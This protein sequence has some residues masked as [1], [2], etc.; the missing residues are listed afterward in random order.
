MKTKQPAP[1]ETA[2][3][4]GP[5]V[6]LWLAAALVASGIGFVSWTQ[7]PGTG[8]ED[9]AAAALET[10]L[11]SIEARLDAL[12]GRIGEVEARP[13][14][15]IPRQVDLA[16]LEERLAE[17][18]A[19][20]A[21][22]VPEPVDLAPLEERLAEIEARPL[23]AAPEQTDLGPVENRLAALE[24]AAAAGGEIDDLEGRVAALEARPVAE[25]TDPAAAATLLAVAQLR[26]A[27]GGSAPYDAAL[28]A[29]EAIGGGD[30]GVATALVALAPHAAAGIATRGTLRDRFTPL[31]EVIL[32]AAVTPP[33]GSWINRTLARLS[34]LVTVR[35]VGGDVAGD[36]VEAIVARA[37]ARLEAG[38]LAAAVGEVAALDGAA[39]E[40]AARWL[41]DARA[42][43]KADGAL[44]ALDAR[45]IAAMGGG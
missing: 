16:P 8:T 14:P 42:R 35:R 7:L 40:A 44:A 24:E 32:R 45:A 38:D 30:A 10:R 26:A 20:P 6:M 4:P 22:T 37:E 11:A 27:L 15:A 39:A 5:R 12:G 18:E 19:R 13:L 41:G 1:K 31:A 23:P 21:A 2:K 25:E 36:S 17:I 9:P 3:T 28:A 33:G 34:G 43:L 29:L